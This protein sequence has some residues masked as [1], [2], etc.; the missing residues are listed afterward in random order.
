MRTQKQPVIIRQIIRQR[1]TNS[2]A[3]GFTFGHDFIL[4]QLISN[5][6]CFG[7][8]DTDALVD[9]GND[10]ETYDASFGLNFAYP[11]AYIAVSNSRSFTDYKKEDT[12]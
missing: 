10:Y 1:E 11:W 12:C 9:A 7:Y 4:T 2:I 5:I 6:A 8:S 3:H